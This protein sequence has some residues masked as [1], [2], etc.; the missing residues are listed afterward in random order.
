MILDRQL[1]LDDFIRVVR[2]GEEV[3]LADA[4]RTR[5]GRARAV[6]ERIV[7]GPEAVYGVNTGFGKFASVRVARE[8]LKQL[9]HN[10]IVSHASLG[11]KSQ[12]ET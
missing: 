9:Q 3:T 8:E 5:M 12:M 4:A 6:I 11:V 2:G 1:T 10:L 7:D